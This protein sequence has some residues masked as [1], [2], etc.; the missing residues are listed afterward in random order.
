MLAMSARK[1]ALGVAVVTAMWTLSVGRAQQGEGGVPGQPQSLTESIQRALATSSPNL[2]AN[3]TEY[4]LPGRVRVPLEAPW[5]ASASGAGR[6][7]GVGGEKEFRSAD[8]QYQ[9]GTKDQKPLYAQFP[10]PDDIKKFERALNAALEQIKR[11]RPEVQSCKGEY[12]C[13]EYNPDGTCKKKKCVPTSE[14]RNA[15]RGNSR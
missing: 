10:A 7:G 13:V 4:L 5:K 12:V 8:I 2:Q 6:A 1:L 14:P 3:N 9:I 15:I 11:D